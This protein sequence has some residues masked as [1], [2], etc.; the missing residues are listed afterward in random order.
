MV[1]IA[2]KEQVY[3]ANFPRMKKQSTNKSRQKKNL[4]KWTLL[5]YKLKKDLFTTL[6]DRF[7]LLG[8]KHVG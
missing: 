7:I 8:A 6:Q 2:G 1:G 3:A 4:L 5:Q